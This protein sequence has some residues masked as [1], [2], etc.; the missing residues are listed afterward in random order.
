VTEDAERARLWR[1]RV[2]ANGTT[3]VLDTVDSALTQGAGPNI[4]R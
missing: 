4:T 3:W 1:D 2:D